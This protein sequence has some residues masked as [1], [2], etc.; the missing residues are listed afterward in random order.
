M[1]PLILLITLTVLQSG[2]TS[3]VNRDRRTPLMP[4]FATVNHN[5]DSKTNPWFNRLTAHF[6]KQKMK[7]SD[8]TI[9]RPPSHRILGGIHRSAKNDTQHQRDSRPANQEILQLLV[10]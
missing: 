7:L 8:N 9:H 6:D 3:I 1:R 10:S 2:C 4:V 5:D